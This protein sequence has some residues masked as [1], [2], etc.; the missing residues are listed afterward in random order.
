MHFT[1]PARRGERNCNSSW[2]IIMTKI[3]KT[4]AEWRKQLT[5]EQ[6]K[7]LREKGTERP[8]TG[9]YEAF[10]EPG[11]YHCA[12]CG[13]KLF[14][15]DAKFSSGCG[16]PSFSSPADEKNVEEHSDNSHGMQRTEVLCAQCA[17][18]LGHVFDDGPGPTKLRYCINSV[19]LQFTPKK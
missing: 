8:G 10:Y 16:W 13:A 1:S 18:H 5:S 15:S 4:D 7:V 14:T 6:Y 2:R 12:A 11:E 9:E 17:S 19:A 3:N